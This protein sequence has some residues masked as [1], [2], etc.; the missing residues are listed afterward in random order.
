[1]CSFAALIM[2]VEGIICGAWRIFRCV[3]GPYPYNAP[4]RPKKHIKDA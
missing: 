2:F 1:L 4:A 3:T